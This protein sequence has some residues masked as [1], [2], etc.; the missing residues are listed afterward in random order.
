MDCPMVHIITYDF[1]GADASTGARKPCRTSGLVTH[2]HQLLA[3]LSRIAPH[4]RLALTHTGTTRPHTYYLR[5]DAGQ[6]ALAQ[7]IATGF[8]DHLG[9]LDRPGKDPA[10]VGHYYENQIDRADN[11][12]YQALARSYAQVIRVAGTRNL[13]AQNINPLVSI[14][15]AE[16]LGHLRA[17]QLGP[18][19]VTGVVHDTADAPR[20]FGYLARRLHE[21]GHHVQVIA[22]SNAVRD[23]LLASGIPADRV[24]TVPN[25]LDLSSFDHRLDQARQARIFA[26]VRAR[27][28]L[29]TTG[30]MILVSA[31][32]VAWKG[33]VEVIEAVKI[34]V[35]RGISDFF[36]VFNGHKMVD[37]R[38]PDYEFTLVRRITAERLQERVFLLDDLSPVEV[39]ACYDAAAIAVH[40]SRL[41]EAWSYANIEA[42]L[43]QTAV[44]AAG[45][46]APVDYLDHGR[47]GLL[48]PPRDPLAAANAIQRLLTNPDERTRMARAGRAVARQFTVESMASDYLRAFAGSVGEPAA[49]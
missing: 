49:A 11:P 24:R 8:P 7:G 30:T 20:R 17:G 23:A 13:L 35:Q 39:A 15:K 44:V 6:L 41:P 18:L 16:E 22:V 40:P 1:A 28:D 10:R 42:M 26:E 9:C 25:G 34:L 19:R 12:V 3:G 43:A 4:V 31:R 29:P 27:N 45:H 32:R 48:V 2:T 5:T 14:L 21:T 37:T 46:G 38:E 47:S 36:V 33:H